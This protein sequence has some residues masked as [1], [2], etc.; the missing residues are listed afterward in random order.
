MG[1]FSIS[2]L[3]LRSHS[4][5]YL[6]LVLTIVLSCRA[7]AEEFFDGF[8]NGLSNWGVS[9]QYD[10]R[11]SHEYHHASLVNDPG[12]ISVVGGNT[13]LALKVTQYKRRLVAPE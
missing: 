13:Y 9:V 11:A 8:D 7:Y 4:R 6:V 10:P 1:G 2:S 3:F 5:A 12:F